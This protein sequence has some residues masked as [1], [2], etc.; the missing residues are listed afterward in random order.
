MRALPDRRPLAGGA[1]FA[2]A[3]ARRQRLH[4]RPATRVSFRPRTDNE[5][6]QL[7]DEKLIA[8]IRDAA[9]VGDV[10]A[11]KRGLMFLVYGYRYTV[12][13]RIALRIPTEAVEEATDEALVRALV[14]AF[15][16]SSRGQF[17]AWLNTII[18]RT[19]ADWYRRRERRP[20]ERPLPSEHLG[21]EEIWGGEPATASEAGA[22]EL[23]IVVEKVMGPLSD[24]H[25]QVVELHLLDGLPAAAVCDRVDGMSADNVAQIASRFRKRLREAI[26]AGGGGGAP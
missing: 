21:E 14:S 5:L 12:R 26:D 22:V 23:R 18:D 10:E 7:T 6:A 17:K 20:R 13:S 25:R 16:G 19:I 15:H 3:T 9:G 8:Y 11:A 1:S 2:S 24:K 4:P